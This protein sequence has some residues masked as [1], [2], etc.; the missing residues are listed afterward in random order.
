MREHKYRAWS[1]ETQMMHYSHRLDGSDNP[2]WS[3]DVVF[4]KDWHDGKGEGDNGAIKM[5]YSGLNDKNLKEIYEGDICKTKQAMYE[6]ISVIVWE[7]VSFRLKPIKE[8]PQQSIKKFKP[9]VTMCICSYFEFEV[10]GN[11]FENPELVQ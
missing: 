8:L 5:Q 10:I 3:W 4:R 7:D 11:I 1:E 9:G 2:L 6:D